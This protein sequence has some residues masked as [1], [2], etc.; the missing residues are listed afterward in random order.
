MRCWRFNRDQMYTRQV[1][2]LSLS[3]ELL[4]NTLWIKKNVSENI[5]MPMS[6]LKR[7]LWGVIFF[8]CSSSYCYFLVF[9]SDAL[10]LLFWITEFSAYL[11]VLCSKI[12]FS[13]AWVT[14]HSRDQLLF[15]HMPDK[16]T[17]YYSV[18]LAS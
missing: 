5:S 17:T 18:V 12:T 1:W 9:D 2:V 4:L 13:I 14:I 6:K 11:Q 10:F 16:H 3:P 8:E 15:G 7:P